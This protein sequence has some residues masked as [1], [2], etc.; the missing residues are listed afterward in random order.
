MKVILCPTD[1]SDAAKNASLYAALLAKDIN[2]ELH[3]VNIMHVPILDVNSPIDVLDS[4]VEMQE[5]ASLAK[6]EEEKERIN[7][8]VDTTIHIS[9]EFGLAIDGVSDK[10]EA[11]NAYLIAMGTNGET[12][13]IDRLLGTVSNGVVKRSKIPTLVI[14]FDA[15]YTGLSK[16]TF[17]DDHKEDVSKQLDFLFGLSKNARLKIDV[18]SV[19]TGKEYKEY[20]EEIISDEGGIKQICVWSDNIEHGLYQYVSNNGCQILAV[21]RH[22]RSFFE[23]LFHKSTTR[24]LVSQAATPTLVFN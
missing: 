22:H 7:E 14:P 3:L 9:A 8:Q 15:E 6:L 10:A 2:A 19:A 17:A 4:L 20:T 12:G 16:V 5:K 21:K 11:I 1:F 13:V 18:V 23:E 24:G